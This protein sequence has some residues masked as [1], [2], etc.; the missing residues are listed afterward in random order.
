MPE[1]YPGVT[2]VSGTD[3][4]LITQC[5]GAGCGKR[6]AIGNLLIKFAVP[7]GSFHAL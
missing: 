7:I 1:N 3:E 2:E 6:E 5:T 4:P